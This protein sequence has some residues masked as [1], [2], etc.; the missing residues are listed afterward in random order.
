MGR[1]T[2]AEARCGEV[3]ELLAGVLVLEFVGEGWP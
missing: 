3:G 2:V 1:R